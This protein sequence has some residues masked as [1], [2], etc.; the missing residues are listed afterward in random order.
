VMYGLGLALSYICNA[1]LCIP[2]STKLF[3]S[4]ACG[5]S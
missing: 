5:R 3:L 1:Y 2:I 4:L